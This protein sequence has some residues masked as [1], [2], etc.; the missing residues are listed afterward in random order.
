M[1][2][3]LCADDLVVISEVMDGP[4]GEL[5]IWRVISECD[6]LKSNQSDC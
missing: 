4:R 5:L 2:E 6:G 3:V 1:Y